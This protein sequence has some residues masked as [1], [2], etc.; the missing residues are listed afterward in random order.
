MGLEK[1]LMIIVLVII[2]SVFGSYYV[3]KHKKNNADINIGFH[4]SLC[5]SLISVP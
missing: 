3:L 1:E 4:K 5:T 2:A